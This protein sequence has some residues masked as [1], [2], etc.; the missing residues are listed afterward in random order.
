MEVQ[1][2]TFHSNVESINHHP[3]F[4]GFRPRSQS[5][6]KAATIEFHPALLGVVRREGARKPPKRKVIKLFSYLISLSSGGGPGSAAV[7]AGIEEVGNG[8]DFKFTA[9]LLEEGRNSLPNDDDGD[10]GNG[11]GIKFIV[12]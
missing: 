8:M 1:E 7:T 2:A 6:S 11:G 4:V 5:G 3:T 12:F 9:S 10:Q